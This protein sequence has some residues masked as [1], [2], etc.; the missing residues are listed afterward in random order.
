MAFLRTLLKLLMMVAYECPFLQLDHIPWIVYPPCLVLA[1]IMAN[2]QNGSVFVELP[3]RVHEMVSD[4]SG[5]LLTLPEP[6]SWWSCLEFGE[7][8][9]LKQTGLC[10]W[11]NIVTLLVSVG[12]VVMILLS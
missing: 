3:A 12:C 11:Y 9:E 2:L 7:D 1:W 6:V 10:F 4:G 5:M 8:D